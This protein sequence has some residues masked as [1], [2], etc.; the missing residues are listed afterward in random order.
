M[1]RRQFLQRALASGAGGAVLPLWAVTSAGAQTAAPGESPYGPLAT[2]PDAN[3]LFLP[4]GFT[5]RLIAVAGEPVADTDYE[6]HAFPDGA[7]TFATDD[8]GWIY[9]CN[10]E[11]GP[12]VANDQGGVSAVRFDA[13]GTVTDAYRILQGSVS[14]CAGG[15]TPWGTWMSCE[16]PIDAKGRLW[17]CDPTGERDAVAHEA[18]GLWRRE[19]AAVDPE[20]KAIYMTEDDPLGVLYRFRPTDYPDLSAGVVEAAIVDES[21]TVT[22]GTVTDPSAADVPTHDQVEGATIF[23]GGEGIWYH[24]GSIYFTSK[25]DNRVHAIDL[26]TQRYELIWEGD[27]ETLGVEGAVLSGVDNITVDA[28]TGDLFVAEDGGNM[29]VVVITPEGA[30]APFLRIDGQEGSEVTGPTFNPDRSRLYFSSQRGP[31]PKPLSEIIPTSKNSTSN[32][33][34]TYEVTGPFRTIEAATPSTTAAGTGSPS[35]DASGGDDGGLPVVLAVVGAGAF[36]AAAGLV[37]LRRRRG[38]NADEAAPTSET[39]TEITPGDDP[40]DATP[41]A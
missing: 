8:G 32:G 33:G 3:G 13:D 35:D 16:E 24:D 11:I 5:S 36:A 21:G 7:A 19:A 6:W 9:V 4:D 31:T 22:W 12:P 40:A 34:I 1:D 17:E 18:M 37:A 10:S 14:N 26:A 25:G 38:A 30:V 39:E 20:G 2:E 29:E 23:P 28:E 27:P 41:P 15:P